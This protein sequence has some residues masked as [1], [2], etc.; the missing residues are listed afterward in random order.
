MKLLALTSVLTGL[1]LATHGSAAFVVTSQNA[2]APA[3]ILGE[4][5]P[6]ARTWTIYS[7]SAL[8][9]LTLQGVADVFVD[10]DPDL[11][12][13][14]APLASTP[15]RS[16]T[17]TESPSPPRPPV[18]LFHATDGSRRDANDSQPVV[19]VPGSAQLQAVATVVV[20]GD[21]AALLDAYNVI[22]TASDG[23]ASALELALSAGSR[24]SGGYVLTQLFVVQKNA[25]TRVSAISSGDVVIG[26]G[27][28]VTQDSDANVTIASIGSGDLFVATSESLAVRMLEVQTAGSGDVQLEFAGVSVGQTIAL[29]GVASG[30]IALVADS[31]T[32]QHVQATLVGSADLFVQAPVVTT[33]T[34]ETFLGGSGSVTV[35]SN[36]TCGN[37]TV[38][39]AGSG[40]VRTGAIACANADVSIFG[41]GDVVVQAKETLTV[42]LVASGDVRYVEP[43]PAQVVI[44]GSL[45]RK[46]LDR[47]V[48]PVKATKHVHSYKTHRVPAHSPTYIHS[49]KR[50][51]HGFHWWGIFDD[52]DDDDDSSSDDSSD[53]S[54]ERHHFRI[55]INDGSSNVGIELTGDDRV[56]SSAM[57]LAAASPRSRAA[58]GPSAVTVVGVVGVALGVVGVAAL[59]YKQRRVRKQYQPL[60]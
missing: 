7:T 42:T 43:A 20:S 21:N 8:E 2:S 51:H 9:S 60:F 25:L 16:P 40:D 14:P 28:L 19:P 48:V 38:T 44:K 5:Q 3:A 31:V 32:A 55:V 59:K 12:T 29:N 45:F 54:T 47:R 6:L 10:F 33:A 4:H 22:A 26:S 15:P 11:K 37:Q 58:N 30:T 56:S 52:D 13:D 49:T 41:S 23:D 50:R 27:V 53:A 24:H 57:Q 18:E 1:A 46:H 34:L 35:A 17:T 36:G 39:V